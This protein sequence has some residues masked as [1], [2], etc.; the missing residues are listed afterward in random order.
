MITNKANESVKRFFFAPFFHALPAG[1]A[2]DDPLFP[3]WRLL[4][5]LDLV[6][7]HGGTSGCTNSYE[8]VQI[9]AN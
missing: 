4:G 3:D 6:D 5:V 2:F 1:A 7:C 9:L 8:L